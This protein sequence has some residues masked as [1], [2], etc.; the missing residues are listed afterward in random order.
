[1]KPAQ[2]SYAAAV[3][4]TDA[5][6][7]LAAPDA[8]PLAG[9]QSLVPLLNFRLAR[10]SLLVD[11]NAVEELAS[12]RAESDAL[13]IGAMTRQATLLRSGEVA[14]RWPLLTQA[15]AHVGHTATRSRGTLGGSVAHADPRAELPVALSA[16]DARFH[17]RAQDGDRTLTAAEMFV[18]PY[19]TA[20]GDGELLVEVEVPSPPPAARMA[21][22]EHARTHGDFALGGVA[23]V[24]APRAHAA[25]ALLG[26]GPVPTRAPGAE[27]ALLDGAGPAEAAAVATADVADD[28]RRSL[29][30]TLTERALAAVTR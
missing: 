23:V 5:L 19:T 26:A 17:V 1:V 9:G 13:R 3:S 28:Y 20:L 24:L 30:A 22:L 18:G 15:L 8:R 21:F 25:I 11:L 29:L 4:V 16:L 10:P 27:R 14:E 12:A 7:L 2:F 6:A